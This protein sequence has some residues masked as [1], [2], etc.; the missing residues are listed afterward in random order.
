MMAARRSSAVPL[1]TLRNCSP[2]SSSFKRTGWTNPGGK[3]RKVL[4]EDFGGLHAEGVERLQ[5]GFQG[6][7]LRDALGMQLQFDPL[8]DAQPANLCES[9]RAARRKVR[10]S[11]ACRIFCSVE[12]LFPGGAG[13]R[14]RQARRRLP[15][16]AKRIFIPPYSAI[17]LTPHL[18]PDPSIG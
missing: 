14:S 9:R 2:G 10:R 5:S 17:S 8:L 15:P 13:A 4:R 6:W 3:L 18:T 7:I 12:S 11:S 1:K 16:E